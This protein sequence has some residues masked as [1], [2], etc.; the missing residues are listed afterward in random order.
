MNPVWLARNMVVN[1]L[2]LCWDIVTSIDTTLLRNWIGLLFKPQSVCGYAIA[3]GKT[4]SSHHKA[5]VVK[6]DLSIYIYVLCQF[7][8]WAYSFDSTVLRRV[9]LETNCKFDSG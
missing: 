6:L 4:V 9:S 8:L 1:W 5:S 2:R 3:S 7:F